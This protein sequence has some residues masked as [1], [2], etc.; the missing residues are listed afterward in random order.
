MEFDGCTRSTIVVVFHRDVFLRILLYF[1]RIRPTHVSS[2]YTT[3]VLTNSIWRI[4]QH[5]I[6]R[7]QMWEH[8]PAVC[9][10]DGAMRVLIVW[11]HGLPLVR[12][13]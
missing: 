9:M 5:Q 11:L 6:N 4:S 7:L 13:V 8:I 10:I 3:H 1:Y 2:D 12:S